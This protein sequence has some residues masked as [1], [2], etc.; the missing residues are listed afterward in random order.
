LHESRNAL[1]GAAEIL[2]N[3]KLFEHDK[4]AAAEFFGTPFE[5]AIFFGPIRIAYAAFAPESFEDALGALDLLDGGGK[6]FAAFR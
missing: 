3:E 4:G 1:D 2:S 5:A 6:G